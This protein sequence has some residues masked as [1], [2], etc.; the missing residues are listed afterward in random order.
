MNLSTAP[1]PSARLHRV[2][3][4][5]DHL[6][7]EGRHRARVR[8]DGHLVVH[9]A[10]ECL[11]ARVELGVALA[12]AQEVLVVAHRRA[13]AVRVDQLRATLRLELADR[14]RLVQVDV[15]RRRREKQ[16]AVDVVEDDLAREAKVVVAAIVDLLRHV[17]HAGR[18]RERRLD[19]QRRRVRALL[20]V[21]L[22]VVEVRAVVKVI[23]LGAVEE[24]RALLR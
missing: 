15:V 8:V 5:R 13:L 22:R 6:L 24:V 3:V 16:L 17:R 12:A 23:D 20:P 19:L 21:P 11:H 9:H 4:V 18:V 14:L 10:V 7:Q 1:A 2:H